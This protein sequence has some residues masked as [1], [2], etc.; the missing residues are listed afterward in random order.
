VL[1]PMD[2]NLAFELVRVTESAALDAAEW[3]GRGN[4]EGA[5]QAAVDAMRITLQSVDMDGIVVIGEGEKDE[6]PMLFNGERVGN[7]N[8]PQVDV[9]V[10]PID[11]T[12]LL[13]KGLPN[14]ISAVAIAERGA[15]FNPT[16]IFYMNKIAVGPSARG[17]IDINASPAENLRCIAQMKQRRVDELTVVVLD[18]ER[19]DSLISD[20]RETGARIMLISHG[21]IAGGLMPALEGTGIDVLMGTGG[22][23]EA[24]I[25]ACALKCMGGE[26]Q[27]KLWPRNED[28]RQKGEINGLD[29]DRVLETD[30]LVG[31]NDIFF[32]A[33]GVTDGGLLRG[34]RLTARGA[35]TASLAMRA[36]SG[37]VRMLET[38]HDFTKPQRRKM[39]HNY[40]HKA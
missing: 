9:A 19:H 36:R 21:D 12:T 14:A 39:V 30:D 18:R 6:A 29:F 13:A 17:A 20:I 33:T 7:G 2:R 4:R 26:I 31:G 40:N 34:V 24:V 22:A 25:T 28:E 10:D 8:A 35:K 27:C 32:A 5:D 37:T 38:F 3:M 16:G 23:P 11:G 15:M 1:E